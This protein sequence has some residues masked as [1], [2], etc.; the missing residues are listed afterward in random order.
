MAPWP[1]GCSPERPTVVQESQMPEGRPCFAWE[2]SD[3]SLHTSL[4]ELDPIQKELLV[5]ATLPAP[6]SLPP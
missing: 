2:G 6:P 5:A 4:A 3:P 1:H